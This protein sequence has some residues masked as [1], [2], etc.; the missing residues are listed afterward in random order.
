VNGDSRCVYQNV[1][2]HKATIERKNVELFFP[3]N[4]GQKMAFFCCGEGGI[5]GNGS[6][7]E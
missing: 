7:L 3:V 4:L 1:E 6:I 5:L 2:N